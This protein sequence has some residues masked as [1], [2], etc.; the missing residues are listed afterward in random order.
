MDT[1]ADAWIEEILQKSSPVVPDNP[2][3]QVLAELL[4]EISWEQEEMAKSTLGTVLASAYDLLVA[5]EYYTALSH[6]GWIY[7]PTNP[8]RLFFH[9]TNCCPRD[10]LK[11][12]FYF[13]PSSKPQSGKIG[14]ATSRLLLILYQEIFKK[15]GRHEKILKGAEPV[16]TIILNREEKRIFFAEIKASPLMTPPVSARAQRLTKEVDGETEDRSHDSVDNT[17]LFGSELELFVPFKDGDTWTDKY[18]PLG[19]RRDKADKAWGYRGM[20]QLLKNDSDFF[21]TWFNSWREALKAYH[22]K[23]PG[24]IFWF[25]NACGAPSPRPSHW[26]ERRVGDGHESIS[27]SKTSVGIDRTD[28]IKKGIYQVLKLGSVGKPLARKWDYKVGLMS[29]IHAARHFDEYLES[30]IDIVWTL[31]ITGRAKKISD[32]P[33]NQDVYDLFDGIIALTSTISRDE[34][35]DAVF[36]ISR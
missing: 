3:E 7:C 26:P 34:W 6:D 14:T 5:A 8:P 35:I 12:R 23:K 27:D 30:L 32:L 25:T 33:P 18:Y 2:L 17:G 22:P 29:N 28:D 11:E 24:P 1:R 15:M 13:H 16:D 9:Y 20:I 4:V 19:S 36:K 10:V 31:D 21:P